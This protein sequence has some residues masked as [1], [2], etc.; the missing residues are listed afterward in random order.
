MTLK[1]VVPT[2][3]RRDSM[4][5]G[6]VGMAELC[7]ASPQYEGAAQQRTTVTPFREKGAGGWH[8]IP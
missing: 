3:G 7:H 2:Q 1:M 5:A 4:G 6:K 8:S